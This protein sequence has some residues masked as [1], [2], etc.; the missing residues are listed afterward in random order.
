MRRSAAYGARAPCKPSMPN[1]KVAAPVPACAAWPPVPTLANLRTKAPLDDLCSTA[2]P[3]PAFTAASPPCS[4][5][6]P[7]S[8]SHLLSSDV[9][10][11]ALPDAEGSG[12]GGAAV[13]GF[14]LTGGSTL[15]SLLTELV[16]VEAQRGA[17]Q[18]SAPPPLAPGL[19][20]CP[21]AALARANPLPL[22]CTTAMLRNI[23]N[24]YTR[25]MLAVRLHE[26]GFQFD[27]DFLY[28]PV[29]F[30]HKCNMGYAFMNFRTPEACARFAAMYHLADSRQKLPGF[31]SGKVCEVSP[32]H[33]QGREENVL[34]LVGSPVM[35]Q[36]IDIEKPEWL[37]VVFDAYGRC[38]PVC[39]QSVGCRA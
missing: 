26:D 29:D 14:V 10:G 16:R 27:L 13:G 21:S 24:K 39:R 5:G 38:F 32:A 12:G 19:E 22:W 11:F 25:D 8:E 23:P 18:A 17:A 37:P 7:K 4:P 33:C 34:R 3:S 6:S 35:A 2:A 28:M 15:R 1:E 31:R 36:L 9:D 20:D 30:K